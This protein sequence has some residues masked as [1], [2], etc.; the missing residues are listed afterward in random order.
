MSAVFAFGDSTIDPG[1][2]ND[3]PT[4]FRGNHVPYGCD[5]PNHT[6]TGRFSNGKISTDYIVDMLGIK[7][8]L[9]A[10]LDH[11]IN[12]GEL[13]TGV[14][15]GA[16]GSGLDSNTAALA[17]VM[18]MDT[19]LEMF[20]QCLERIRGAVGDAKANDIV[21]NALFVISSGTNDM[22]FNAYLLPARMMQFGSVSTYH[23]FLLQNLHV[24][25]QKLYE[26]GARKIVV[27][28][29]PPIG[30]LPIEV[31]IN[32]AMPYQDWLHRK[33]IAEWNFECQS[34][35]TKLQS[36]INSL[37]IA[38]MGT[39]LAYFDI[40]TPMSDMILHPT[41]YGFEETLKGCCG[42]GTLEMGPGCNMNDPTCADPSKYLFWD[43][44][45]LTEAGYKFLA[46]SG[47]RNLLPYFT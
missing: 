21:N 17:K 20:K 24:F 16:G 47:R 14:S 10:Y 23:D 35:N 34:Y 9:L 45:H 12:D 22:L 3:F 42:S 13:L 18:N 32:S 43:A 46:E 7:S 8:L 27:V 33:C 29:L 28:G 39:K 44:V 15:F 11:G 40:F 19:Q 25:I 37:Q 1:N 5:F 30:C 26:V 4:L 31:T 6:P 2:N 41:T 38:L 36:H